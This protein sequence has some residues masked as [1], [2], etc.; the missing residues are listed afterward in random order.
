MGRAAPDALR[1]RP[2][3]EL[4]T[5]DPLRARIGLEEGRRPHTQQTFARLFDFPVRIDG[6]DDPHET[7]TRPAPAIQR[8][9][10]RMSFISDTARR[11]EI[12]LGKGLYRSGTN[13]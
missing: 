1:F 8:V 7:S 12:A 6:L 5:L 2:P 11:R 10:H 9:C 3:L 4:A 13:K